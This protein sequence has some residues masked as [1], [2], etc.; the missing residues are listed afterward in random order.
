MVL[1]VA[2]H[3]GETHHRS[4]GVHEFAENARFLKTG[5]TAEINGGFRVTAAN[6]GAPLSRAKRINVTGTAQVRGLPFGI[7]RGL[8]RE[9]SV[10]RAHARRHAFG[11]FT[12]V[13]DLANLETAA[14]GS[15]PES[16]VDL[17]TRIHDRLSLPITSGNPNHYIQW[18]KEVAGVSYASC[19][20]LWAGNGTVKVVI[21]GADK[22]PVD[23]D[24]RAA[25]A[26]HIEEERPIGATVTVVSVVESEIA[27]TAAVTLVEGS[28]TTDVTNQLTAAVSAL[29]TG[30][31]FGQAVTIPYSRFLAC[32]LQCEGVADYSAFTVAGGTAAVQ[33]AA[34]TVP[35]VGSVSVTET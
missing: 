11:G 19:I 6:E 20:P 8:D 18:A 17:Y 28:S 4:V 26:A 33:I 24:I 3:F 15:D 34:E 21:A 27:L 29:L 10:V 13:D 23:E 25:C 1:R 2:G 7:G 16:D 31:A 22:G 5:E 14:G 9:E 12:G 35:V 30:Q 32:L